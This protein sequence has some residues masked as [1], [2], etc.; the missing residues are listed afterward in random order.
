MILQ[1]GQQLTFSDLYFT[2]ST[3]LGRSSANLEIPISMPA[4]W[5]LLYTA[6]TPPSVYSKGP[7][8]QHV[9]SSLT[10]VI[11]PTL[12]GFFLAGL[13]VRGPL[14]NKRPQLPSPPCSLH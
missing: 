2:S 11:V 8:C 7:F 4:A 9:P 3:S 13:V 14:Y 1:Y 10:P 6:G 5:P 12:L